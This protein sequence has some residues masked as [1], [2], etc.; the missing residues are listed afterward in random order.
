MEHYEKRIKAKE[1]TQENEIRITSKGQI[2]NYLNYA[3]KILQTTDHKSIIISATGNAIVK[4]LILV[5]LVKRKIG[6][7]H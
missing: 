3:Q 5:E 4:A 2:R 6:N 7:L 1:R